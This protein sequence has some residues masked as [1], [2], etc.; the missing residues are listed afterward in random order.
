MLDLVDRKEVLPGKGA[1]Y[2]VFSAI[3][4]LILFPV[5]IAFLSVLALALVDGAATIAGRMWGRTRIRKG[6]TLE[7]SLAGAT[8]AFLAFLPFI[9]PIQA[10]FLALFAAF[11]ELISPVDDNLIIPI[12][13]GL[14]LQL[15]G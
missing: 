4:A 9:P 7:G 12:A 13:T 6:K 1:L 5:Q 11:V 2:F 10:V 8:I 14:F 15:L 3:V